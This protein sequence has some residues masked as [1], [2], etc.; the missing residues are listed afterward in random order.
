M[1]CTTSTKGG[2]DDMPGKVNAPPAVN[3]A[4]PDADQIQNQ[5]LKKAFDQIDTEQTGEITLGMLIGHIKNNGIKGLDPKKAEEFVAK[6]KLDQAI[7]ITFDQF[8]VLFKQITGQDITEE[9]EQKYSILSKEAAAEVKEVT[10][11]DLKEL[12]LDEQ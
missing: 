7:K 4:I 2:M 6:W 9:E 5:L 3:N 11:D 8:R 1:G 10:N 12:G